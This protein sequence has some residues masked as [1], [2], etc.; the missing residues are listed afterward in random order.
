MEINKKTLKQFRAS[1]ALAVR[2]LEDEYKVSVKLGNISYGDISFTGK[3]EV[4]AGSNADEVLRNKFEDSLKTYGYRYPDLKIEH[5]DQ[6]IMYQG[7]RVKI[8]GIKP[9]SPKYPIVYQTK[10]GK[11]WKTSYEEIKHAMLFQLDG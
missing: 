9:R 7:Q 8:V 6:G 11:K 3:I 2:E 5:F 10:D 4:I 1:F